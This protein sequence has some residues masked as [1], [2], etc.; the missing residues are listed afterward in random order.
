MAISQNLLRS[1][2][3]HFRDSGD[4]TQLLHTLSD[5]KE[6][7]N[8]LLL[9][10]HALQAT[11]DPDLRDML[12][13]AAWARVN[14]QPLPRRPSEESLD[15]V[16]EGATRTYGPLFAKVLPDLREVAGVLLAQAQ[17]P[18][19][20]AII[21]AI[22]FHAQQNAKAFFVSGND[23]GEEARFFSIQCDTC[24][25]TAA[26]QGYII[27][28]VC[29]RRAREALLRERVVE[30]INQLPASRRLQVDVNA[31]IA[32]HMT[33]EHLG[34]LPQ[35]AVAEFMRR[36]AGLYKG[37]ARCNN[38]PVRDCECAQI[39]NVPDPCPDGWTVMGTHPATGEQFYAILRVRD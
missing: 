30:Q 15:Q 7:S 13:A 32:N 4:Y 9:L 26:G 38:Q 31:T 10:Q 33:A 20:N 17:T 12:D 2:L 23:L 27:C 39:V 36:H 6:G 25:G 19:L 37:C 22:G 3:E 35:E 21:A 8:D 28:P 18:P 5:G 24:G 14:K 11:E 29:G 16:A 34:A 1:A